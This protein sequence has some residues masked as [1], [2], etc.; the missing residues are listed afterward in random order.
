ML[1]LI[2]ASLSVS[3]PISATFSKE[4]SFKLCKPFA[5]YASE[6]GNFSGEGGASEYHAHYVVL[7]VNIPILGL[8]LFEQYLLNH[9]GIPVMD[10]TVTDGG[11]LLSRN[12]MQILELIMIRFCSQS[13]IVFFSTETYGAHTTK[14]SYYKNLLNVFSAMKQ[15]M[16][17]KHH[18]E[19]VFSNRNKLTLE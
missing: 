12:A 4:L 11:A 14:C 5:N 13:F 15:A 16:K 10:N 3:Q 19:D 1:F 6:E 17:R 2:I 7:P 18:I 8:S 9:V